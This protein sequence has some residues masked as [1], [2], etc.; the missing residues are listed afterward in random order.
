M[1]YQHKIFY[2]LYKNGNVYKCVIYFFY[3]LVVSLC[4]KYSMCFQFIWIFG[5]GVHNTR[6]CY[7]F[8]ALTQSVTSFPF[9]LV[10]NSY[11]HNKFVHKLHN[12]R[13]TTSH[14]LILFVLSARCHLLQQNTV[15]VS[16]KLIKCDELTTTN[17][18]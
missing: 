11:T 18:N 6:A 16:N 3:S 9:T 7:Y 17:S 4:T 2:T 8:L 15:S 10:Y 13:K 12:Y 5:Y 1:Q 14:H